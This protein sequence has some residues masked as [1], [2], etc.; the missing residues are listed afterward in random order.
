MYNFGPHSPYREMYLMVIKSGYFDLIT[1]SSWT[2]NMIKQISLCSLNSFIF[3]D[4]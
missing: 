2:N 1:S 3:A 4:K